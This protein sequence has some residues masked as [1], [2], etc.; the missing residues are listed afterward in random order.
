MQLSSIDLNNNDVRISEDHSTTQQTTQQ[1][2]QTRQTTQDSEDTLI[3]IAIRS[4]IFKN[5]LM[6]LASL[7]FILILSIVL[8]IFGS[9]HI[10]D[11]TIQTCDNRYYGMDDITVLYS[12]DIIDTAIGRND[13]II[14][15]INGA[16]DNTRSEQGNIGYEWFM[17]T[18]DSNYTGG[19]ILERY[20]TF[21][22]F[23]NHNSPSPWMH[24]H[25][26]NDMIVFNLE[27]TD[28]TSLQRR[29]PFSRY[30][31]KRRFGYGP[32]KQKGINSGSDVITLIY[33]FR[34]NN[35]SS[36]MNTIIDGIIKES[37]E[38][39]RHESGNIGYEWYLENDIDG[40]YKDGF[41]IERYSSFGSFVPSHSHPPINWN[42]VQTPIE[43]KM[44]N[45]PPHGREIF[46]LFGWNSIVSYMG[47][48]KR[49][50]GYSV[51]RW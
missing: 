38:T 1:T 20:S 26:V 47:T 31:K 27:D 28:I 51:C 3:P 13:N 30:I 24:I 9:M 49:S 4:Y 10:S 22:D 32:C 11:N 8:G 43:Y 37:V 34:V 2:R 48:E 12:F 40:S 44:F 15:I 16:V 36:H 21:Q 6:V 29:Y 19:Y 45:I 23:M 41:V 7:S 35:R 33:N 18:I 17:N 46:T 25:T 14:D 5:R 50:F 42:A 39:T